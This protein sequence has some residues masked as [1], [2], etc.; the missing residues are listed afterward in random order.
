MAFRDVIPV[1]E[2]LDEMKGRNFHVLLTQPTTNCLLQGYWRQ[3]RCSWTCLSPKNTS[4][5]ETDQCLLPSILRIFQ[6]GHI[7]VL[8]LST[9]DQ[10]ANALTKPLAQMHFAN[11]GTSSAVLDFTGTH[12][13]LHSHSVV[14]FDYLD[15]PS[16]ESMNFVFIS[17][18]VP[19]PCFFAI[20]LLIVVFWIVICMWENIIN[21]H[22]FLSCIS[23]LEHQFVIIEQKKQN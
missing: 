4:T 11:T 2:L 23:Q 3:L 5:N 12:S 21:C 20:W 15:D 18:E 14:M 1:M 22:S 7:K 6:V 13:F 8:H 9:Y 16:R 10:I 19:P 17:K